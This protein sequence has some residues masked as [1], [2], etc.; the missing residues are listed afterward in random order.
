MNRM[1]RFPGDEYEARLVRTRD[2]MATQ[3][4]THLVVSDPANIY[5]LT[6]FDACS[7]YTPQLLLVSMDEP[8]ALF[9][10]QIDAS[11]VWL[12]T[13]LSEEQVLG[14]PE[15]YVQQAEVHP[16]DWIAHTLRPRFEA[17]SVIGVES[18]SP[19]YTVRAHHALAAGLGADVTLRPCPQ[20][21]NW[22]RAVK[23]PA[24]IEVMRTAGR[25]T[26]KV[27]EVAF[28]VI[29]PGVRQSDAVAEIYAAQIRGLPEAGGSHSAI[30]PL[31]LA[32]PNT[33][34]PH[35]PWSD[36]PFGPDEPIALELAGSR[37]R[38]HVPCARTMFLGTP[39]PDL[40]ALADVTGQGLEAA[41]AAIV[42]GA[43]TG[44][45]ADA[46]NE[47]IARHGYAKSGR[48]G[49][50]VGIGYAPDWGE[51]TMSLR[52]GEVTPFE[53]GMTFHVM[54]GMWLDGWGY[55]ISETVLVT[56]EGTECLTHLPRELV[57]RP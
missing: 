33:A 44:A 47:V 45:P 17:G 54:I 28:D 23:S 24:E 14:Y 34:F 50:P 16:M 6:G 39:S 57:R 42:P 35:V 19:H 18:D 8:L 49:Y 25:I 21:V 31:V 15:R 7:F 32:G 1:E 48:V 20:V 5:Y 51:Q 43:A 55:S 9:V 37:L 10:R 22:V 38:Y 12:T 2:R 27:F 4:L 46:W 52:S 53:V 29:R 40:L 41:L 30:P 36:Q 56:D 3:G 26:E 11:S 13:N